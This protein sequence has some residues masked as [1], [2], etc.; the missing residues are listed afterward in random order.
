MTH[1][2]SRPTPANF[3]TNLSKDPVD[4]KNICY[5]VTQSNNRIVAM[6][7]TTNWVHQSIVLLNF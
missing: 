3:V 1:N 4:S 2:N 7:Q 5:K 6:N